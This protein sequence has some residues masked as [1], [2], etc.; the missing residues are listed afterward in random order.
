MGKLLGIVRPE[1]KLKDNIYTES[2]EARNF[3]KKN[4]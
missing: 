3:L 2:S 4:P 1:K